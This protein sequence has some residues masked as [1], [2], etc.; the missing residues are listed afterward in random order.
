MA[1]RTVTT[2]VLIVGAGN[3]AMSAAVAARERGAAVVVLEKAPKEHRG[4]NS[5]LTVHM[6]FPYQG[7]DDLIPLLPGVPPG[8]LEKLTEHLRDYRSEDY[9]NDIMDVTQG[10]CDVELANTLVTGAY[11]TVRWMASHGHAWTPTYQNPSSANLVSFRGGGYGLQEQWFKVAEGLGVEVRYDTEATELLQDDQGRVTGVRALTRAGFVNFKGGATIL[12]C[13]SF[14]SNPEMR[15]EYLGPGWN[16]VKLRGV[17]Y[18]T[19]V[20][21]KAAIDIGA[22]PFGSWSTCHASPQ[23]AAR[24]AYDLPGPGVT[25]DYW[26]RYA[27]PFGIMVNREGRRFVDEGETWRGLTY[28]K[29][30]RAILAQPGAVAFQVFDA[31]HR[32]LNLIRG[33]EDA[34]GHKASTLEGLAK[35]MNI[36]DVS[37]FVATVRDFNS[38][39]RQG[40]FDPYR[41]D[42]KG[43][44]SVS[45]PKSN[46]ALPID[47]PIFE[48]FPVIC[49]MTF[50]YG[51]LRVGSKGEVIHTSDRPIAGLYAA[52]EMVGGLWYDN[53]PSGG[54]MMAGSVFG[55]IAGN[56]AAGKVIGDS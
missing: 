22:Q 54:G 41:L 53:Y 20:G 31:K 43:A 24:P 2:Q 39:V 12:A 7:I 40:D 29:M 5:A 28:A 25:G 49:G 47:K 42:G 37:S 10:Q 32:E 13:G 56:A 38:S 16:E 44:D 52:G 27:Y 9:Y 35:D 18:N 46:W 3:A 23:D 36:L 48:A 30:G 11:D 55:R 51:G 14:E 19:G 17:P 1:E 45:P 15:A 33:Y 50:T 8:E 34:I 6:R 21:L 4:G 26:S